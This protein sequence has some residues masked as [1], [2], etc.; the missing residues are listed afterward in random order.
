MI[1]AVS[2]TG[3]SVSGGYWT[4]QN[5]SATKATSDC[6]VCVGGGVLQLL[7]STVAGVDNSTNE[8]V[9]AIYN[10]SKVTG[11]LTENGVY[12]YNA[13]RI[14]ED[15]G[16]V[17]NSMCYENGGQAG[18]HHECFHSCPGPTPS[19]KYRPTMC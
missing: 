9:Y 10:T 7:H 2:T 4:V 11:N 5:S 6:V 3:I 16:T 17:E 8:A 15:A 12:V 18:S 1:N 13:E 14:L 19:A